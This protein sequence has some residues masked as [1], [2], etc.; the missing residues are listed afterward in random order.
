MT[1][2]S[3]TTKKPAVRML[4]ATVIAM[5]RKSAG[6]VQAGTIPPNQSMTF[7][8][9]RNPGCIRLRSLRAVPR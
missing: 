7:G 3:T 5:R 1:L 2:K 4:G 8:A 6:A 9:L